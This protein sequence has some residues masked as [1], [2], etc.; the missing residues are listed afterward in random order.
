[1][2]EFP[3]LS[4]LLLCK[5][6]VTTLPLRSPLL[7]TLSSRSSPSHAR[8]QTLPKTSHAAGGRVSPKTTA[9]PQSSNL[10]LPIDPPVYISKGHLTNVDISHMA[11]LRI[12]KLVNLEI[13]QQNPT[14]T[15]CLH[16]MYHMRNTVIFGIVVEY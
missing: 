3:F 15:R 8:E 9:K 7:A 2:D 16:D 10:L 5:T 14:T 12:S 11:R 4:I 13:F 1:M 6:T